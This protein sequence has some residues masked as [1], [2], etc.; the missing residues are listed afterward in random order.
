MDVQTAGRGDPMGG[1]QSG[2]RIEM[3]EPPVIV[4]R[5]PVS[6]KTKGTGWINGEVGQPPFIFFF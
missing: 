5:G 2:H 3:T 4:D 1:Q 6:E